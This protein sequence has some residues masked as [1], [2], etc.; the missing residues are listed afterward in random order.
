MV[1]THGIIRRNGSVDK[2]PFRFACIG[3]PPFLEDIILFPEIEDF[4]LDGD[5]VYLWI[6]AFYHNSIIN[7]NFGGAKINLSLVRKQRGID[8]KKGPCCH[9]PFT[10]KYYLKLIV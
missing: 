9:D 1:Y 5:E 4:V 10:L 6:D 3:I 8:N 2:G 7:P